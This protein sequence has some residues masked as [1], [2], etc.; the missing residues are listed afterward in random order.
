MVAGDA[1]R[2]VPWLR[3][4]AGGGDST[5]SSTS[6]VA[7]VESGIVGPGANMGVMMG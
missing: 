7:G 6:N 5:N 2:M 1:G 4:R 3:D